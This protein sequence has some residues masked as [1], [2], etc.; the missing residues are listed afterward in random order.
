MTHTSMHIC[1]ASPEPW[2]LVKTNRLLH[3]TVGHKK[4]LELHSSVLYQSICTSHKKVTD[5]IQNSPETSINVT[6][7]WKSIPYGCY[8]T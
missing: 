2:L 4:N 6:R 8:N 1:A 7:I 3:R 5:T